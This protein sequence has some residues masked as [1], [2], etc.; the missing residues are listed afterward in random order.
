MEAIMPVR[1]KPRLLALLLFVTLI[2][3]F[4]WCMIDNILH[5]ASVTQIGNTGPVSTALVLEGFFWLV[6]HGMHGAAVF[7]LPAMLIE[8]FHPRPDT[9]NWEQELDKWLQNYT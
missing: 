6:G 2:L 8:R 7:V 1:H 5:S 9:F 3:S 4:L